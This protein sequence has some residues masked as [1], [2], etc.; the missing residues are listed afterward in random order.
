MSTVRV[1]LGEGNSI[2]EAWILL[3]ANHLAYIDYGTVGATIAMVCSL[4]NN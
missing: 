2:E 1:Y 4:I 3:P